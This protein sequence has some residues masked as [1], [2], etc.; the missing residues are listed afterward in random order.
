[1]IIEKDFSDNEILEIH[2]LYKQIVEAHD[3]CDGT[4]LSYMENCVFDCMCESIFKY[5]KELL[6]SNIPRGYWEVNVKDLSSCLNK[7]DYTE[8]QNIMFTESAIFGG[9]PGSGKTAFLSVIGKLGIFEKKSICYITS[10]NLIKILKKDNILV[11]RIY[12]A[13]II[14][15]DGLEKYIRTTWADGQVEYLL[16]NLKDSGKILYITTSSSKDELLTSVSSG[17]YEFIDCQI[18]NKF[19]IGYKKD[20]KSLRVSNY[21]EKGFAKEAVDHFREVLEAVKVG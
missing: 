20:K 11:D 4:G 18:L 1:M 5:C 14:L 9:V 7:E 19:G 17:I 8:F 21:F 15:F 13:E 3:H 2:D 6:Y 12:G 16:R 10:E